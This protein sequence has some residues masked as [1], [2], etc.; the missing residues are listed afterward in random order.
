MFAFRGVVVPHGVLMTDDIDGSGATSLVSL[1][2]ITRQ[3]GDV[4][5]V[6]DINI[7]VLEGHLVVLLGPSGCGKSTT[8]RL[9]AGFERPDAG[10]I[11]ISGRVVADDRNYVPAD[12]RDCGVVF[13]SYALWPHRTVF[14]NVAY[15]L[16]VRS[17]RIP[18]DDIEPRVNAA[19][20]RVDL[21]GLSDRY[22][23]QLSGGQQQRVAL[24]RALVIEPNLLLLDEPLSNLD[25]AL[26]DRMRFELSTLQRELR[27][28][29]IYVTH[30]QSE[31]LALADTIVVLRNGRIEQSGP[32]EEIWA[33][34]TSAYAAAAVGPINVLH[35][36]V[37][38]EAN[39]GV[40]ATTLP[41]SS[42]PVHAALTGLTP[43]V[44]DTVE[45]G[46]RPN[47]VSVVPGNSAVV[48]EVVFAGDSFECRVD[49]H[50]QILE[51]TSAQ[52]VRAGDAVGLEIQPG[53][54]VVFSAA[55]TS[56]AST[57]NAVGAAT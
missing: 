53:K 48:T 9:I 21:T 41:G 30:D 40:V 49:L 42:T 16:K 56:N 47:Q 2:G 52:S 4:T 25:A 11:H 35:A 15:G 54:A 31:A 33:R 28:T 34:P 5:A 45:I 18:K 51:A 50:G 36:T 55:H 32:P 44:G 37:T 24:A 20:E 10:S 43:S 29:T 3:F 14:D 38:G 7:E 46:V 19:L 27:V 39:N 12:K 17:R 26:R 1:Q 22:P 6:D 57:E 23:H 8:L 13:Q